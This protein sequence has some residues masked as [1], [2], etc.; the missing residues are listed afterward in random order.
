M[1]KSM[2]HP[3]SGFVYALTEDGRVQ[4]SDPDSDR[5]GI[6]DSTG[7]WFSGEIKDADPQILGWVGRLPQAGTDAVT[8]I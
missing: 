1:P 4:V 3:L 8:G 2:K 5:I 6:F 7:H